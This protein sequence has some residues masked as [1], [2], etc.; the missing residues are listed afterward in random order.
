MARQPSSPLVVQVGQLTWLYPRPFEEFVDGGPA[1]L[2]SALH[3]RWRGHGD[4]GIELAAV[5]EG[6]DCACREA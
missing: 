1:N 2:Y 6:Y 5:D 4:L 3:P